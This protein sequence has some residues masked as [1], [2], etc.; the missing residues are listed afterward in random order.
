MYLGHFWQV[1]NHLYENMFVFMFSVNQTHFLTKRFAQG[2][3]V[4]QRHKAAEKWPVG[5]Y[6]MSG[7]SA[8][9][10]IKMYFWV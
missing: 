8:Q 10:L 3:I 6:T 4:K 7:Y 5:V 1:Q 2:L 9:V